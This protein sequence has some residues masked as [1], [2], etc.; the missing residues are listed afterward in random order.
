MRRCPAA[1]TVITGIQRGDPGRLVGFTAT[2]FTSASLSPPLVSFYVGEGSRTWAA[3]RGSGSFGVSVLAAHQAG[4]ANRFAQRVRDRF[5]GVPWRLGPLS[6]PLLDGAALHLVCQR[7]DAIPV[8]DHTLVV[9]L[10]IY[11]SL[12]AATATSEAPLLY[13]DGKYRCLE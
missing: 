12:G 11:S 6:V 5:D 9:G 2:S 4:I 8:G 7:S 1:V 3:L 13:H 10:V